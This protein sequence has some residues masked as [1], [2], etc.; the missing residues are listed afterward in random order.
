MLTR[1]EAFEVLR[2][3]LAE[4][5]LHAPELGWRLNPVEGLGWHASGP[6][7]RLNLS[8]VVAHNGRADSY[9]PSLATA[10]D[11]LAKLCDPTWLPAQG[12]PRRPAPWNGTAQIV[13]VPG[14][15]A[16]QLRAATGAVIATGDAHPSAQEAV[17]RLR[18]V[19]PRAQFAT[20]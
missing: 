7:T 1:D 5:D 12:D 19:H 13:E 17:K 9:A 11:V 18:R 2:R 16:F 15:F 10:G 8:F 6:T 14:G 4:A 3:Y 20:E